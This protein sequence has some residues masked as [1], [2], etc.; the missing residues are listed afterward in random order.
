[1]QD[2]SLTRG[3]G[4]EFIECVTGMG[5]RSISFLPDILQVS[6]TQSVRH[7]VLQSLSSFSHKTIQSSK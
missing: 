1:M 4:A 2:R 7:H 3:S 5:L 6:D